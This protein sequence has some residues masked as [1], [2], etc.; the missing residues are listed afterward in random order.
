MLINTGWRAGDQVWGVSEQDWRGAG[1]RDWFQTQ[2]AVAKWSRWD[3]D[4]NCDTGW[5][6]AVTVR[7]VIQV[8]PWA[9]PVSPRFHFTNQNPFMLPFAKVI[10]QFSG[11]LV[12]LWAMTTFLVGR[13]RAMCMTLRGNCYREPGMLP[14]WDRQKWEEKKNF[15]ILRVVKKQQIWERMVHIVAKMQRKLK[16]H[17][18]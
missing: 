16:G 15:I 7:C 11:S 3:D 12:Q 14:L 13:D 8:S 9:L 6:G 18:K 10:T 4:V 2:V 17:K 5:L 1:I